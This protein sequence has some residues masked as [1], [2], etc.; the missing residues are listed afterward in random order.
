M[1]QPLDVEGPKRAHLVPDFEMDP[2]KDF[3]L[4]V[5]LL[6]GSLALF[7]EVGVTFRSLPALG[8]LY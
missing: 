6:V 7:L 5:V 3:L 1:L 2:V 4:F 8:A